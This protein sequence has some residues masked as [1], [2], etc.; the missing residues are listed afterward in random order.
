M[1][2]K[3]SLL[4]FGLALLTGDAWHLA[5]DAHADH[6]LRAIFPNAVADLRTREGLALGQGQWRSSDTTLREIA[7]RDVGPDLKATGP[8]NKTFDFM[9]AAQA[10]GFG[11]SQWEAP[12]PT[13]LEQ[14]RGHGRLSLNWYRLHLTIP[15]KVGDFSTFAAT[16]AFEL[17]VDDYA[18]DIGEYRQ[19]GSN[20]L[21]L[22]EQGRL[23]I[24]QR[25]LWGV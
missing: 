17:V 2:S 16:V 18:V 6:A 13:T 22:D 23:T 7:H 10:A 21:A 25:R 24:C 15:E 19:P 4:H 20:G 12:D 11:D 14:R 1:R 3:P 8:S 5:F 9:P